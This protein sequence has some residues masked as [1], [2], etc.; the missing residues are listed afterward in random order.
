MKPIFEEERMFLKEYG[1]SIPQ[2]CWRDGTKIYLNS[3]LDIPIITFQVDEINNQIHIKKNNIKSINGN[4]VHIKCKHKG[5][6]IDEI[7]YNKTFQDEA[8]ENKKRLNKLMGWQIGMTIAYLNEHQDYETRV[9]ISGGK[10]SSVLNYMFLKW[11]LPKLE[12]QYFK[13]DA[14]NTTNDTADTYK[15]M[16]KEGLD[17]SDIHTPQILITFED[18]HRERIPMGWHQWIE[19]VKEYWIPNV[20]K[21]SC[22]STF[23]E[24]QVKLILDKNKK[25]ITLLGVRKYESAKRAF[26]EFDIEE[27]YKKSKDKDSKMPK[28]WKRI[29]PICYMTDTD[30]WL[31]IILHNIEF[32]PMYYKG[33][34]RVGCL[35]CPY[36]SEY[37]NL[38]IR[39]YYPKQWNRWMAI[40]SKHYDIKNVEKR[41]KW[42]REEYLNGKWKVGL[43]KEY[44][45]ISQ[46]KTKERIQE[47]ARIKNISYEMAEKYWDKKCSCGKKLNPDEIAMFYKT[48]GRY[49]NQED[50]RELL[51]KKCLCEKLE[52]SLKEYSKRVQYYRAEGCNLF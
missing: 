12:N 37:T 39:K 9:S 29:A 20:L 18:G 15:Q 51:C 11:V 16:Y 49:E 14:F 32:N 24:G 8:Q 40:V 3:D 48:F 28:D 41:L 33:F 46:K 2:Y 1:I 22:C 52:I 5:K 36:G 31:Y 23:K 10:D 27:A 7:Y 47:L 21:R 45:L 42:T 30:I 4:Q 34:N 38:L 19:K 13:Y 26:Y 6:N 35:I 50:N 17:K 44:E 25:Y 43:S